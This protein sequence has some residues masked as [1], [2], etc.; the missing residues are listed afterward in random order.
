MTMAVV[1][2][3]HRRSRLERLIARAVSTHVVA[4]EMTLPS[5]SHATRATIFRVSWHAQ[6]RVATL[7]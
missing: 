3:S 6:F 7:S 5:A 1:R 4:H 2:T